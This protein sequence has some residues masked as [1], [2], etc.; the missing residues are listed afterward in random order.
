MTTRL[1]IAY[2]STGRAFMAYKPVCPKD[3]FWTTM[4]FDDDK[5]NIYRLYCDGGALTIVNGVTTVFPAPPTKKDVM[6]SYA[7]GC[8]TRFFADGS[9]EQRYKGG[10]LQKWGPIE[11]AEMPEGLKLV[12]ACEM[13][14]EFCN[15]CMECQKLY[16]DLD[17]DFR[18]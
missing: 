11:E 17:G 10:P 15:N 1:Q 4:E 12:D 16:K 18:D 13:C 3:E 6:E 7:D 2:D 14:G 9:I 5:G 8:Y